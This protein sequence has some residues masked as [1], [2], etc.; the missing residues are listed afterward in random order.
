MNYIIACC[1]FLMAVILFRDCKDE[2]HQEID[3]KHD[4]CK[5]PALCGCKK[6]REQELDKIADRGRD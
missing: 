5:G 2:E 4:D 3:C 1:I 6:A